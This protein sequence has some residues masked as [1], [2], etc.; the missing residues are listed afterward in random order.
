VLTTLAHHYKVEKHKLI[1]FHM[2]NI[3][4]PCPAGKR[5][6]QSKASGINLTK[7]YDLMTLTVF[8]FVT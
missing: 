1:T 6:V 8:V 7:S 4:L 5:C 2:T 3:V